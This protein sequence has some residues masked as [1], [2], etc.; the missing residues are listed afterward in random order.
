MTKFQ[1]IRYRGP[2][3]YQWLRFFALLAMTVSQV[4]LVL[5]T[6]Y[7][8]ACYA[9]KEY[10]DSFFTP[11][12]LTALNLGQASGSITFPLLLTASMAIVLRDRKKIFKV[13]LSNFLMAGLTSL[14][15]M[16][17]LEKIVT[18]ILQTIPSVLTQMPD[19]EA[20]VKTVGGMLVDPYLKTDF[21]TVLSSLGLDGD[22]V[23]ALLSSMTGLEMD[24]AGFQE[25][26][27][28]ISGEDLVET[29]LQ[30]LPGLI[31]ESG[32]NL[33]ELL[34]TLA[35]TLTTSV[36]RSHLN[37][38]VFLDLFLCT[39]FYFFMDYT[40]KKLRGG[41]LLLFRCCGVFPITYLIL[42]MVISGLNR[43][44]W[45]NIQIPLEVVALLPSRKLPGILLFLFMVLYVKF[46]RAELTE[47][48]FTPEEMRQYQLSNRDSWHFGLFISLM[49][50]L[51][52]L[53]DYGLSFVPGLSGW[54]IGS[55]T[56]LYVAVPFILLFSYNRKVKC[57]FLDA[58]VP[59]YYVLN[60]VFLFF[61]VIFL[62]HAIP[63]VLQGVPLSQIFQ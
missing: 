9:G 8:L 11:A 3:S 29:L 25:I 60:Y 52:S 42:G 1:D 50:I 6:V 22:M 51:L 32:L 48:G 58:L 59:V 15:I 37:V 45:A 38:N 54:S 5:L 27:S 12:L 7:K 16:L 34:A 20:L 31:E 39:S 10:A 43:S 33:N 44:N 30:L 21:T 28:G 61:F 62:I 49:L 4:S 55:S 47:R 17:F 2:L 24:L 35:E 46:H 26:L 18:V 53:A 19:V 41:K 13:M 14:F 23:A 57:K 63:Q 36:V 56:T 40:P